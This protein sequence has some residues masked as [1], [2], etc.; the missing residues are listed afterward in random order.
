MFNKRQKYGKVVTF[1]I[2]VFRD[3]PLLRADGKMGMGHGI[4]YGT[5]EPACGAGV[6][7][8]CGGTFRLNCNRAGVV[9]VDRVSGGGFEFKPDCVFG[10]GVMNGHEAIVDESEVAGLGI[11]VVLCDS[12]DVV[13]VGG[14]LSRA[15]SQRLLTPFVR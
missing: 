10:A 1:N 7:P 3:L 6:G 15:E 2:M 5:V 13:S 8:G 9:A 4:E 14:C 11:S 12:P